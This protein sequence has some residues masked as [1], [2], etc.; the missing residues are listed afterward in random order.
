MANTSTWLTMPFILV[1]LWVVIK[2]FHDNADAMA[3]EST[4]SA[5]PQAEIKA[6]VDE[7]K[8]TQLRSSSR[9]SKKERKTRSRQRSRR[10]SKNP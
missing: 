6:N 2:V 10:G 1:I 8:E 3:R 7:I 9:A 5:S 4:A